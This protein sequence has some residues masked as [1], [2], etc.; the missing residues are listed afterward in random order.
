MTDHQA[1]DRPLRRVLLANAGFS[2]LAALACLSAAETVANAVFAP[3]LVL[4][5]LTPAEIVIELGILLLAFAG[6]V[7]FI[8]T[9]PLL[10]RGWVWSVIAADV[11]WVLDS[12]LSLALFPET[13]T[14]PGFLI[15]AVIA[16]IVA[17]F[18]AGQAIGLA[19]LYQGESKITVSQSGDR[20][21]LTASIVTTATAE[22]VW[23]V[24]SDQEAYADVADNLS[25]VEVIAGQGVGMVRQCSDT[26]GRTWRETCTLWDE[27]RAFGFR[28]HT[29]APGYPYPIAKLAGNWSLARD[30]HGTRISMEF[31]IQAKPGLM[32]RMLFG[33]MAAPFARICD[34]LLGRWV[35]VM[36]GQT[37]AAVAST[38]AAA[39]SQPA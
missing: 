30:G 17:L 3:G 23:Q 19:L 11:L 38:T 20:M 12:G 28:V 1:N 35:A 25:R 8:A 24:M 32:N 37:A 10:R 34:R 16:A 14:S 29:E 39:A 2:A 21:T 5:A 27:G 13:V 7:T 33:L 22:R 4:L 31:D 15:V 36:E 9:R 18:A 26:D 6:C